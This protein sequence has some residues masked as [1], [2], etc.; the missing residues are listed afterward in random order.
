MLSNGIKIALLFLAAIA[1][2][3]LFGEFVMPSLLHF[4]NDVVG[5]DKGISHFIAM[6]GLLVP[7][8]AL[9]GKAM[10]LRTK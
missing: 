7:M 2:G 10:G 3:I 8:G 6:F 4:L 5:I 1:Y 9:F